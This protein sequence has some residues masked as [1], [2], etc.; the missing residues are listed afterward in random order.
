M[1]VLVS[2]AT[3]ERLGRLIRQRR[4]DAG[5]STHELGNLVG[6]RN[7]TIIRL[8]QGAFAAPS[9]EKLARI[10]EALGMVLADI[11]GHAGYVVPDDLPGFHACLPGRYRDLPAEAVREQVELFETLTAR[12]GLTPDPETAENDQASESMP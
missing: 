3:A 9:P 11:F 10:A 1:T 7:S 4:V 5:L 6:T 12:H 8:E 2:T